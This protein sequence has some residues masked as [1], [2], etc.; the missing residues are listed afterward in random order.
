MS[1]PVVSACTLAG[2]CAREFRRQCE[3]LATKDDVAKGAK[4]VIVKYANKVLKTASMPPP[5][6]MKSSGSAVLKGT[7]VLLAFKRLAE[8]AEEAFSTSTLCTCENSGRV[9][10]GTSFIMCTHCGAS[11]CE[12]CAPQYRCATHVM[13][14]V[15]T[16]LPA[17]KP[18]R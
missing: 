12:V 3:A 9:H 7:D 13:K 17:G 1:L 5:N 4:V 14:P 11:C 8:K 10:E 6:C 16:C 15:K 18:R 2:L